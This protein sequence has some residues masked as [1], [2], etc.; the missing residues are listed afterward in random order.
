M[1]SVINLKQYRENKNKQIF[2]TPEDEADINAN[3][4]IN[5]FNKLLKTKK[6]GEKVNGSTKKE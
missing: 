3:E 6:K 4:L 5:E 1:A 2:I